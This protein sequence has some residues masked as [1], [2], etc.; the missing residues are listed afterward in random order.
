MLIRLYQKGGYK[1]KATASDAV[2]TCSSKQPRL[3]WLIPGQ[4]GITT[5]V[6]KAKATA[7]DAVAVQN[8]RWL[9][10]PFF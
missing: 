4:L 2:S 10:L 3:T 6:Y 1:A 7:F 5:G 9:T 8:K